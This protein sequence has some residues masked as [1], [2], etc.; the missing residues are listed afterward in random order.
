M[1]GRRTRTRRELDRY[2]HGALTGPVPAPVEL[3]LVLRQRRPGPAP[4]RTGPDRTAVGVPRTVAD[5]AGAAHRVQ[6]DRAAP[7]V[8]P[9]PGVLARRRAAA[10]AGGWG[11]LGA[12]PAAAAG[13]RRPAAGAGPRL[14]SS[15]T[16]ISYDW[17][18]DV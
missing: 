5:R 13:A 17:S 6:L 3:G 10:R 8:L 9:G 1:G 11:A 16:I 18:S 14:N 15:H 12:G 4:A 7:R 2:G